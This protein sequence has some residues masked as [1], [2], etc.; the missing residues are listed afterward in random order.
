MRVIR[1]RG[2]TLEAD[3]GATSAMLATAAESGEPAVRVWQPPRQ[4]AFG[5]R[6]TNAADYEGAV[7]AAR[8]CGFSPVE[9][10]VGG[11]A[12]AYTGRTLAFAVAIMADDCRSGIEDRYR[13]ATA[14]VLDGLREL[15]ADVEPG[16]PP[17]SYCP[18]SHS[19]RVVDGGKVA[20]LAQRVRTDVVLVS[21]CLVVAA[22]DEPEITEVLDPVY[23]AL[24]VDFD[25]AS[26]GSV[27]GAGGSATP[28]D[29]ARTLEAAFV[30][31]A[32]GDDTR[33]VVSVD[34][35]DAPAVAEN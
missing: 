33:R 8:D 15:G 34:D 13:T 32:W 9:R 2:P 5:R 12:V 22:A 29:A 18:G 10:S 27:A 28:S 17:A 3:R 26:V 1:G 11:R 23:D 35:L 30:D 19:I 24:D 14:T 21:G 4:V 20:G 16:E 6:D 31:G 25:P 7:Q